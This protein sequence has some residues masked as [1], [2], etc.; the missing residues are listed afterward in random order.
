VLL[1]VPL[2]ASFNAS[3]LTVNL[4]APGWCKEMHSAEAASR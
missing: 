4:R 3:Q 2:M 1:P